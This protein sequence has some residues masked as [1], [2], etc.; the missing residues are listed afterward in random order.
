MISISPLPTYTLTIS[1][2]LLYNERYFENINGEAIEL[3]VQQY[4]T[5]FPLN[6]TWVVE[7]PAASH[8]K[9]L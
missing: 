2:L 5:L 1:N 9:K 3:I 8:A 4:T 6:R 7:R